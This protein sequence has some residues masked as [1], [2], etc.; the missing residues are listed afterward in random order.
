MTGLADY[1]LREV[2][3]PGQMISAD[4]GWSFRGPPSRPAATTQDPGLA[5]FGTLAGGSK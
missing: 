3:P 4:S 2:H 1:A 5:A